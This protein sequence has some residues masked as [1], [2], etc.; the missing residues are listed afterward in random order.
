MDEKRADDVARTFLSQNSAE[1]LIEKSELVNQI[2]TVDVLV[3]SYDKMSII[4]VKINKRTGYITGF[5]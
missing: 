3:S 4:K 1:L 2:W 5:E